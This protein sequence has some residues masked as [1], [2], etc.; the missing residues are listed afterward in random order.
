MFGPGTTAGKIDEFETRFTVVNGAQFMIAAN[1]KEAWPISAAEAEEFK[2]LYRRR[3]ERAR[4]LRRGLLIGP[5]LLIVC[6][7]LSVALPDSL[8]AILLPLYI[9]AIPIALAQH[10][11]TSDLTRWGIERRLKQRIT[12]RL[13]AAITPPLTPIGHFGRRLLF[14][15][16][17]LEIGMIVLH[18]LLG[19]HALAEHM[20]VLYGQMNGREGMLAR[21]TGNLAWTVQFAAMLAILLLIVDRRARRRAAARAKQA[22]AAAGQSMI[23]SQQSVLNSRQD[24]N[25]K[26]AAGSF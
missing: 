17:A 21:V 10:P 23:V 13:P 7:M 6:A 24:I 4:W 8:A 16:V 1:G 19:E 20:R 15:C 12:T 26:P 22:A 3:M 14:A 5:A 18:L 11:I 25:A 9:L 2:S